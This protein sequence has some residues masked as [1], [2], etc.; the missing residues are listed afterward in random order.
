MKD[1]EST[2]IISANDGGKVIV[3]GKISSI[4]KTIKSMNV[5]NTSVHVSIDIA[6]DRPLIK[7]KEFYD[8][9]ATA[10]HLVQESFLLLDVILPINAA[11]KKGR[12]KK[13]PEHY[14]DVI[15]FY[16]KF[17]EDIDEDMALELLKMCQQLQIESLM[18]II[19]HR[20]C[21]TT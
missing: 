19:A 5:K 12:K 13:T 1:K 21:A 17:V 11:K 20:F 3:P 10:G 2:V 7:L 15:N 4:S 14:A 18:N 6:S 8:F 9:Y 16:N